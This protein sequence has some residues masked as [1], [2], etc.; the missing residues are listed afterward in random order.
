MFRLAVAA[1][2]LAALT[3]CAAAGQRAGEAP[4]AG[5]TLRATLVT[6]VDIELD[7]SGTPSAATSTIVEFATDPDGPWTVLS[8]LTA[9]RREYQHPDLMPGTPF[10]HRVT[11]VF[12]PVSA[13][14]EVELP[15]ATTFRA[16]ASGGDAGSP[17]A[18]AVQSVGAG[19]VRVSWRDNSADEEGFLLEIRPRGEAQYRVTGFA[20]PGATSTE[21][22]TLPAERVASY[23]VRAFHRGPASNVTRATTGGTL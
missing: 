20:E 7:W 8:V 16:P 15:A 17:S 5:P 11:P 1:L 22:S 9:D 13:A 19:V 3:G 2:S 12:G 10:H 6:P 14:V 18:V 21:L 23:R 4:P